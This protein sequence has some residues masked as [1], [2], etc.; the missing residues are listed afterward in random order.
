M[1]ISAY[2]L[3][4]TLREDKRIKS[5]RF[6]GFRI[7]EPL[8]NLVVFLFVFRIEETLVNLVVFLFVFRIEEPLVNLVVFL[9]VFRLL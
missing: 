7:E 4:R 9:F 3:P 1:H 6:K 8:V 2:I 5:K